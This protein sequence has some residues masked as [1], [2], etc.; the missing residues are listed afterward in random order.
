MILR[1]DHAAISFESFVEDYEA[2]RAL[3]SR[4]ARY[5]VVMQLTTVSTPEDA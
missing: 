5:I 1:W 4:R 3:P 2:V